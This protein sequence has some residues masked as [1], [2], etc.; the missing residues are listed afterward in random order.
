MCVAGDIYL[1]ICILESIIRDVRD[2]QQ[3]LIRA[4]ISGA[5]ILIT[6]NSI[7]KSVS[8]TALDHLLLKLLH[9][10][11]KGLNHTESQVEAP[12][13]R[14]SSSTSS[15]PI[16]LATVYCYLE[17][18]QYLSYEVLWLQK[19]GKGPMYLVLTLVSRG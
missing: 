8:V 12:V 16:P 6:R 4:S 3:S 15:T 2:R 5:E 19:I 17:T 11:T 7:D 1:C 18:P 13:P 9:I 10:T 14:C